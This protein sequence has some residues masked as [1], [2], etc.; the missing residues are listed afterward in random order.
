MKPDRR[1]AAEVLLSSYGFSTAYQMSKIL[2]T[3]ADHLQHQL[4]VCGRALTFNLPWLQRVVS[5]TAHLLCT[6]SDSDCHQS[7]ETMEV[8]VCVC[9]CVC[10]CDVKDVCACM[11]MCDI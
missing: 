3:L 9:A 11:N 4:S 1:L 7:E 2:T 10:A 8:C 5:L 6:S